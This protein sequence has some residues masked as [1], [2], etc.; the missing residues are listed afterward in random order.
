MGIFRRSL[1]YIA[2]G[3][4]SKQLREI[5]LLEQKLRIELQE[6]LKVSQ[7][8]EA[9]FKIS[10]MQ[11]GER[12][13]HLCTGLRS[14]SVILRRASKQ[15][16]A[17]IR[18]ETPVDLIEQAER[19]GT[20]HPLNVRQK[21]QIL[22]MGTL[23]DA[24]VDRF[25]TA[26]S[27]AKGSTVGTAVGMGSWALVSAFGTASTGTAISTLS[28]IA[29]HNAALAWFGGGALA[30]GGGGMA[31]GTLVFGGMI[32]IPALLVTVGLGYM[33]TKKQAKALERV[34]GGLSDNIELCRDYL[35]TIESATEKANSVSSDLDQEGTAFFSSLRLLRH[36]VYPVVFFSATWRW[37]RRIFT[38]RYFRDEEIDSIITVCQAAM[39][40]IVRIDTPIFDTE[41]SPATATAS[42]G[43]LH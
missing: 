34:C 20:K 3:G 36:Q 4:Q 19:V 23:M 16:I 21:P 1:E 15:D 8:S 22:V 37:L 43:S 26:L 27:A 5:G 25:N 2:T 30:A 12:K 11:L 14:A 42:A 18:R 35:A 31:A 29:A 41:S 6:L 39:N 24:T 33:K 40:V 28:G 17:T 10:L 7:L 13:K 9:K 32:A 38:G